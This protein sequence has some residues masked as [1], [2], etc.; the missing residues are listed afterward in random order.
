MMGGWLERFQR[1]TLGQFYAKFSG[2]LASYWAMLIAWQSLF[3][4]FP[5]LA[6]LLAGFGLVLRDPLQRRARADAVAAQFPSQVTDLLSFMEETR[7][8]GGLLAVVSI[9]GLVWSGFWLFD[10]MAFV[11]NH[12]Y[13]APDRG[14]LGQVVMALTMMG[15]YIVLI[16][17]S[18]GTSGVSTYLATLTDR[19]L[20]FDV[21]GV[22]LVIGWLVS[23][24]SAI[25]MFLAL[26]RVVPNMALTLGDVWR[27]AVVAG[28]L[29]LLLNQVF[30]L[31]FRIMGGSYASYKTLGLFLVLMSWFYFLAMILVIGAE[32]N[33]FLAGRAR[34][35]P[36]EEQV[37][38]T[39]EAAGADEGTLGQ[40][41]AVERPAP[42][43]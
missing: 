21:P 20:P 38:R 26:Y 40:H 10:T 36:I 24:T 18:V 9:V 25:L 13:G 16:A 15:V 43:G 29:F 31:Y 4:L 28:V 30:P 23:L 2:D 27:G 12:F 33:A 3:T 14:Y 39:G 22:A 35:A 7:E 17:I 42:Q 19:A 1:S 34:P 32:L 41:G 5:L 37:R 6:G 11:F 8:L